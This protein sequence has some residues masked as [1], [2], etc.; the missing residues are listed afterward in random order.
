MAILHSLS[1]ALFYLS[2]FVCVPVI[3]VVLFI[4]VTLR[5]L[6]SAPIE[7]AQELASLLL[8]LSL[9]LALPE[10]WLSGVHIRA[11]FLSPMLSPRVADLLDRISWFLVAVFSV[12]VVIQCWKDAQFMLLINESSAELAIPIVWLRAVLA[13]ACAVSAVI[14]VV[15]LIAKRPQ[16]S[17]PDSA[18]TVE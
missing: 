4:D 9:T 18:E 10:S 16:I 17:R 8:F 2:A 13:L 15:R 1:K 14:A 3:L 6:F 12:L 11:D 5:Y 7:G